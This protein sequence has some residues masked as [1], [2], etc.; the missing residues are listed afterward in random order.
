[1]EQAAAAMGLESMITNPLQLLSA[2]ASTFATNSSFV[3]VLHIHL[4][5]PK[6]KFEA[7]TI[8]S[9]PFLAGDQSAHKFDIKA[10]TIAVQPGLA[11]K[12]RHMLVTERQAVDSCLQF[13][14]IMV[15]HV[16]VRTH[17]T[18]AMSL[19]RHQNHQCKTKEVV[20][21][22]SQ[23][24]WN[25]G[26]K[27]Y[28]FFNVPTSVYLKCPKSNRQSTEKGLVS[29]YS[30]YGCELSTESMVLHPLNDIELEVVDTPKRPVITVNPKALEEAIE[31]IDNASLETL[32][33]LI[34]SLEVGVNQTSKYHQA[35]SPQTPG[36]HDIIHG[37]LSLFAWT[38]GAVFVVVFLWV[39]YRKGQS[40]LHCVSTHRVM[41][42]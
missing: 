24:F 26:P 7:Y 34:D 42:R 3:I 1:M 12:A 41:H 21:M 15:C 4:V 14:Q 19:F 13:G 33:N 36:N 27:T 17:Q 40:A 29:L 8:L 23:K 30:H 38:L 16:P 20:G 28:L 31:D 22:S 35:W 9:L 6:A 25:I 11:S 5:D 2:Q 37:S 39:T 10:E 18:C 32:D